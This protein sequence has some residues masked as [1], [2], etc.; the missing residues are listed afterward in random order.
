MDDL[1]LTPLFDGTVDQRLLSVLYQRI[2]RT[3]NDAQL[4][5]TLVWD[6]DEMLNGD[7]F[8]NLLEQDTLLAEYANAFVKVG[9]P[10]VRPIFERAS[11]LIPAE[12]QAP[13]KL[14]ERMAFIRPISG[15]LSELLREYFAVTKDLDVNLSCF[16]RDHREDFEE[17]SQA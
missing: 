3:R 12:I 14:H 15:Q 11:L 6:V 10:Q 13:D 5:F 7:G 4:T 2:R 8:E 9:M 16:V 1:D 17:Y